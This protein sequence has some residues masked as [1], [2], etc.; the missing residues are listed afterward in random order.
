LIRTQTKQREIRFKGLLSAE[1]VELALGAFYVIHGSGFLHNGAA[2]ANMSK[3]PTSCILTEEKS[4]AILV[5]S[6]RAYHISG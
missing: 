3:D 5:Q 6:I 4:D 1:V 2:A